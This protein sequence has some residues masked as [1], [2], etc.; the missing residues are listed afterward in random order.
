MSV[1][2]KL[3]R[4]LQLSTAYKIQNVLSTA[5][6]DGNVEFQVFTLNQK[7]FAAK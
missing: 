4:F 5:F 1:T 7:V 2:P 6:Y 3:W